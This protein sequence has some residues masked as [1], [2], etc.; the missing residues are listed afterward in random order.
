MNS[1]KAVLVRNDT[2][3]IKKNEEELKKLK[4]YEKI[5]IKG[6]NIFV[7]FENGI[8]LIPLIWTKSLFK[9][10]KMASQN[11]VEIVEFAHYIE[12][13]AIIE[14]VSLSI[15]ASINVNE[16]EE[17]KEEK[18]E[19]E[20]KEQNK[21]IKE[22]I[23]EEQKKDQNEEQNEEQHE[24]QKEESIILEKIKIPK[25]LKQGIIDDLKKKG[26]IVANNPDL[27]KKIWINIYKFLLI[28]P[29][30][31]FIGLTISLV[32]YQV[33]SLSFVE[34]LNY[35][36][37]IL[38]SI[39]AYLGIEKLKRKNLQDWKKVNIMIFLMEGITLI[40]FLTS[41]FPSL[42]GSISIFIYSYRFSVFLYYLLLG[43]VLA[44]CY[45][46]N[47]EMNVFYIKYYLKEQEGKLL[48]EISE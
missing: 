24:E 1:V 14:N 25:K 4:K 42:G 48:D 23:K 31:L 10:C 28:F 6:K 2:D 3:E 37:S 13:S 21:E 36:L 12:E 17:Q 32:S 29:F 22:E 43:C 19:K 5:I 30:I 8:K 9:I 33:K 45:F 27:L 16:K 26:N 40:S 7:K 39:T 20:N 35:F 44:I 34:M 46:L 18:K 41:L 38:L 11:P 15:G 47:I